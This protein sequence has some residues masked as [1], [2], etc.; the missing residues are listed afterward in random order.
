MKDPAKKTDPKPAYL[1]SDD[2]IL[3][4]EDAEIEALKPEFDRLT[5]AYPNLDG[6]Q[7]KHAT[8]KRLP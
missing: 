2:E 6:L 4:A 7:G 3:A 1:W 5:A 8:V